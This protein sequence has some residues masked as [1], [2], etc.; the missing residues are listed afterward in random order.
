MGFFTKTI[1]AMIVALVSVVAYFHIQCENERKVRESWSR[2]ET[3]NPDKTDCEVKLPFAKKGSE[4]LAEIGVEYSLL[5]IAPCAFVKM[6]KACTRDP[7]PYD[8]DSPH[9]HEPETLKTVTVHDARKQEVKFHKTGFTL[10]QLNTEPVT[11]D[12][13]TSGWMYP[14][15]ADVKYFHDQMKPHIE[16]LYPDVKK[17]V[18][19]HNV[20]RGGQKLGKANF[21]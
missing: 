1:F 13:R 15:T 7:S 2:F 3:F 14:D 10:I 19:T 21:M 8:P 12:W 16:S 11:Q 17:I 9:K 4:I 5:E 6:L 18:W 20:V